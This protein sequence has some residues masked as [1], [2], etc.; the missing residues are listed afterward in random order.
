MKTYFHL[1]MLFLFLWGLLAGCSLLPTAKPQQAT[2]YF[3][4]DLGLGGAGKSANLYAQE[5]TTGKT[6]EG[7]YASS[8]HGAVLRP[9]SAPVPIKV[10]APGTYVFYAALVEDPMDYHYGDTGCKAGTDCPP[11]KLLAI[12]VKPGGVYHVTITDLSAVLPTPD[13]PVNVPWTR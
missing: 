1:T 11:L 4:F 12:D 2:V 9:T 13:A 7:L 5:V 8:G 10:N 3:N 6:Y